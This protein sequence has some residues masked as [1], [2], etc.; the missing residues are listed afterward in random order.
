MKLTRRILSL[1]LVITLTVLC[2][3]I[4]GASAATVDIAVDGATLTLDNSIGITFLVKA[5]KLSAYGSSYMSVTFPDRSGAPKEFTLEP[6][7]RTVN[8][9][10]YKAYY[11]GGI[12][13]DD[14][15]VAVTAQLHAVKGATTYD[16]GSFAYAVTDYLTNMIGKTCDVLD[17]LMADVLAYGKAAEA[18]TGRVS[19]PSTAALNALLATASDADVANTAVS[20]VYR[21]RYPAGVT[22]ADAAMT[23]TAVGVNLRDNAALTY[24]FAPKAGYDAGDYSLKI[25]V[26]GHADEVVPLG[27]G[28]TVYRFRG[29]SATETDKT[30]RAV[31]VDGNG[32]PVSAYLDYSVE[33][34]AFYCYKNRASDPALNALTQALIRYGRA[35]GTY[36][37][38][39]SAPA[40]R[41]INGKT[42]TLTFTDD[43]SGSSL[44]ASKW[45]YCPNWNRGNLNPPGRWDDSMVS[46]SDGCL[47]LG[48]SLDSNGVPISGA[49][50]TLKKDYSK[51]LFSQCKGYFECRC[52][53]QSVRG[54][55]GAFWLMPRTGMDNNNN[56]NGGVDGAEIDIFESWSLT[57]NRVN[58]GIHWDGYGPNSGGSKEPP[59]NPIPG[60]YQGFHTF[61][62]E[63]TDT[64]YVFYIDGKV[65]HRTSEGGISTVPSYMKLTIE[66]GT[67]AGTLEKSKLPAEIL[68]DY[69][70]VWQTK[71]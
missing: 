34:Y 38:L 71:N 46:V 8:G 36:H 31:F 53:L 63:W 50:R 25:S 43:F 57:Q 61:G 27:S 65:T 37:E 66:C 52:Q 10:A 2:L 19:I 42:Y 59:A 70:R 24:A 51:T 47:R 58:H 14:M 6:T 1:A 67:W 12:A 18:Y 16:A 62:L 69:V 23:F 4:I 26:D 40:T 3:P 15:G 29:L 9:V 7:D 68:V 60:L 35:I 11:F 20:N 54:F 48:V 56:V 28:D 44:D 22:A 13:P 32:D 41:V 49:V 33:S 5:S 64:E 45:D 17:P 55:W 30:V 39:A 21:T